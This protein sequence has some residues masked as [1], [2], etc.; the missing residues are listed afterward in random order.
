MCQVCLDQFGR[1]L[2]IK[3][4]EDDVKTC[5]VCYE[6]V[7]QLVEFPTDCGHFFC[8]DCIAALMFYDETRYHLSPVQFG[9]PRCP[10]GCVNPERGPQCDCVEYDTL[11]D[12][13]MAEN[14]RDA[15]RWRNAESDS[16]DNF[17]DMAYASRKCPLCRKVVDENE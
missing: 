9:C 6:A 11:I 3:N 15:V 13:W 2:N 12:E 1:R 10:N 4:D 8:G 17:D 16:I 14:R 7:E 5:P